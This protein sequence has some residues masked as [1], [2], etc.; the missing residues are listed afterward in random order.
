MEH[1]VQTPSGIQ[2]YE[3]EKLEALQRLTSIHGVKSWASYT[4]PKDIQFIT[5]TCQ[6]VQ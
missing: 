2:L 6:Y 5:Y 4:A 1:Q 3:L